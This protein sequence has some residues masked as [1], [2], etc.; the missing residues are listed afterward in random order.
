MKQVIGIATYLLLF[1][2][3]AGLEAGI[4]V[5]GVECQVANGRHVFTGLITVN[6]TIV[7]PHAYVQP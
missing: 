5:Q 6:A 2:F 4:T 7:F 3:D 1:A